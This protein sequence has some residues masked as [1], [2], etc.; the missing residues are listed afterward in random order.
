MFPCHPLRDIISSCRSLSPESPSTSISFAQ[1]RPFN[2]SLRAGLHLP[3]SSRNRWVS[4]FLV[5]RPLYIFKNY[6][7]CQRDFFRLYLSIFNIFKIETNFYIFILIYLNKKIRRRLT[8]MMTLGAPGCPSSHEHKECIAAHREIISERN[9]KAP[10]TEWIRKYLHW[11]GWEMLRQTLAKKP[12]PWYRAY[13]PEGTLNSQLLS[14]EWRV[15]T[16]HLVLQLFRLSLERWASQN[17]ALKANE[18]CVLGCLRLQLTK[19][20]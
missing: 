7:L 4:N 5:S 12:H 20:S 6:W 8:K 17:L 2:Q 15:W 16:P 10:H 1:V 11:I 14:E 13:N 3:V 19:S 9:S 18:A